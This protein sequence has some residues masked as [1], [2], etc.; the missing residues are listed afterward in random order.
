MPKKKEPEVIEYKDPETG[1]ELVY[2]VV[3]GEYFNPFNG[4]IYYDF[5]DWLE[6][7][8]LDDWDVIEW[9][10]NEWESGD[11]HYLELESQEVVDHYQDYKRGY[12]STL[13]I[14]KC[15]DGKFWG[16][17]STFYPL[18]EN[19]VIDFK[20]RMKKRRTKKTEWK[21]I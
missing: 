10:G 21:L 12:E 6:E 17:Q 16:F 4:F 3:K 18:N 11:C 14:Y 9:I 15:P 5:D 7:L 20:G 2:E 1:E 19:T 13:F 8:D